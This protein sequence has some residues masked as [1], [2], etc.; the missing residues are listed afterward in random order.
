MSSTDDPYAGNHL[1][2]DS[3]ELLTTDYELRRADPRNIILP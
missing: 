3:P 1:L 2:S